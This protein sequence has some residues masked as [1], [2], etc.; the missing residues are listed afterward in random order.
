MPIERKRM[1][2]LIIPSWYPEHPDDVN[3]IF[4]RQQVQALQRAGLKTG[5]IA[6]QF[7]SL[8]GEP[9]SL[10]TGA[11]GFRQYT[12]EGVPTYA[13]QSMYFFPRLPYLDRHR[14]LR[15]G[16]RLFER[17]VR[18][19]GMPEL[20]HAHSMNHAGILAAQIAQKNGIPFVL[21]EHSSTYARGLIR[22]WQRPAMQQAA[23]RCAARIA[24]SRDFCSLLQREYD[25]LGWHYI[26][27]SLAPAFA[28]GFDSGEHE[29]R[30]GFTFCSV[31][32]LNENKGFDVLLNAFA[33][34]LEKQPQLKLAIGGSGVLE[35]RLRT[36]AADLGI[37]GA[38]DFLGALTHEG[39]LQLMR[40]SDAF[41]LASRNETFGLVFA[42]A[43][44]QGL[45]VAG[46]LCGGAQ[47]V[48][49]ADDGILVP[50]GDA[51]AL[52]AAMVEIYENRSR[53]PTADLRRN[54][55]NRFGEAAVVGQLLETYRRVLQS[56]RK[57]V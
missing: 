12:D 23:E 46:T 42:E 39:V 56:G 28:A 26:P 43:L 37:S 47:T 15:A 11:Y 24:V 10:L 5:V 49:G 21:T 34:T 4:F 19:H 25:G 2:I 53:Y 6:P 41:V 50:V 8:R 1:H 9:K 36:Q 40:R 57:A 14:W 7:R 55:L 16:Y 33:L 32:N 48:V 13:Y 51:A 3:G 31:A 54:C 22:S 27:N 18:D 30:T 52:A 45:P 38:V 20:I 44:S 35:T 29:N 17:Y